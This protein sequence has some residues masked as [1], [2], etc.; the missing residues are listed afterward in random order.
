M[1]SLRTVHSASEPGCHKGDRGLEGSGMFGREHGA[2]T[3]RTCLQ[4]LGEDAP[5]RPSRD[6]DGFVKKLAADAG[7]I[8]R[9]KLRFGYDR[10]HNVFSVAPR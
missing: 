1:I 8:Q 5:R 2:A 3:S 9:S 7:Q 10:P 4:R 6:E